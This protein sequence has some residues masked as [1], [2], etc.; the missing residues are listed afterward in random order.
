M[1]FPR[2]GFGT[3]VTLHNRPTRV[4]LLWLALL[5]LV[6][7]QCSTLYA[8]GLPALPPGAGAVQPLPGPAANPPVGMQPDPAS[9][10]PPLPPASPRFDPSVRIKDITFIEGDRVNHLSGEG[11]V[12]GL[13]GTGGKSLQTRQMATNFYLRKGLRVNTV[14]TKNMSAVVV[15]GKVPAFARKGET[16]LVTV[17][18]GDDASSLRGGTL[19]QTALRGIDDEIYAIAQGPI[20]GGGI[21]AQGAAASVQVNHPTVGVCEAIVEREIPC[22][23]IVNN[24]QIRIVLRNKSYST[25]TEITNALNRVFPGYARAT[26]SGTVDVFI[27]PSFSDSVTQFVSIIGNL[28]VTPDTPARVVINQKTGSVVF[29]HHVKIAPVLFASE[30]IVIAT[31]ETAVASQ[32]NPLAGGD[33]TVLPRTGIDVFESGGRYNVLPA[34]MT[35]GDLATALNTLAVSP[36]TLINIMTSLRNHG[37]LKA[38]LVIE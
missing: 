7:G 18:V 3:D 20:I 28:R 26:D 35:V 12:F 37:A 15:S 30:N 25:A 31:N 4:V 14:D 19:N 29:G 8:Q 23:S 2:T 27:P 16:I 24:G 34:G 32:P 6:L 10:L 17:S 38:E 13:S 36:T 5:A 22:T 9:A 33:T 21:S 1:T 11:L